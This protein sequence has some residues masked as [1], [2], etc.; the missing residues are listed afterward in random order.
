MEPKKPL[1][2]I[3]KILGLFAS[4]LTADDKCSFLNREFNAAISDETI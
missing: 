3:C 1:F 4:P 2:V